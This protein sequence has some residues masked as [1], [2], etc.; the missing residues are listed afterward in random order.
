[1]F[2]VIYNTQIPTNVDDLRIAPTNLVKNNARI[3]TNVDWAEK[4]HNGK[5]YA[6]IKFLL[7]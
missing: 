5:L 7:M 1:M 2:S 6:T 3:P 4:D